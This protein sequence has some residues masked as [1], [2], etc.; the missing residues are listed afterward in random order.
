MMHMT[1]FH[2]DPA[3]DELLGDP[4]TQVVMHADRVDPLKLEAMLRSL[5]REI[6]ARSGASPT[7]LVEVGGVRFDRNAVGPLSRPVDVS[8]DTT[9]CCVSGPGIRS[10]HW[11]AP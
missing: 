9:S 7:A 6:A 1:K 8:Q 2:D 10:Q 3:L 5:A 11:K 4:M